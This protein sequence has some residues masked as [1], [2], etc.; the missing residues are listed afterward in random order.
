MNLNDDDERRQAE[1]RRFLELAQRD[2]E[3][4]W[5]S[6]DLDEDDERFEIR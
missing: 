1:L 5:D 4:G 3:D 2:E 6:D